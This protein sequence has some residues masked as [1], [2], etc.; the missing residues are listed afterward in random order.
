M[1]KNKKHLKLLDTLKAYSGIVL[2]A[3]LLA[4]GLNLF[5]E[6]HEIV[7]GGASGI[8]IVVNALTGFPMGTLMLFINIPLFI[9]GAL[10]IKNGFGLKT[11][12]GTVLFSVFTDVTASI[13]ALTG[14]ILMASVFGGVLFGL[15][16]GLVFLSGG[17]TGGTDILAALGHKVFPAI[18]VGKWVF[19]IDFLVIFFGAW[20]FK[21]TEAVLSG[22]LALFISSFLVDYLISGANVAK[23]VYVVSKKSDAIS[24]EI[25][26]RLSR[27]VTGIYAKGMYAKK[28][29]MM[30]MCVVKGFELPKLE[31]IVQKHDEN[32][33]FILA[34]ARQVMGLGFRKFP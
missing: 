15:G 19:A 7:S 29:F 21:N 28:D 1:G 14:N 22:V 3:L 11:L 27:G 16:F 13:P 8:A 9:I 30:L 34:R 31:R 12:V 23:V 24:E 18:N 6:P 5:L 4:L 32:A 25:Q 26:A 10:V 20:I 33:F 17:T 2:G